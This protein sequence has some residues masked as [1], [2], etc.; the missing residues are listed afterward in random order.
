MLQLQEVENQDPKLTQQTLTW[1]TQH[2][3]RQ[4]SHPLTDTIPKYQSICSS[5]N[6]LSRVLQAK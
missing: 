2:L 4:K 3:C 1:T 6:V 5:D